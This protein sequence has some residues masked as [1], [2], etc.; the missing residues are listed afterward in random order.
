MG[1]AVLTEDFLQDESDFAT[2]EAANPPCATFIKSD[3]LNPSLQS[4][5]RKGIS[6]NER[7]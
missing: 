5:Q 1:D 2:D 6:Q 7:F 3:R 4:R